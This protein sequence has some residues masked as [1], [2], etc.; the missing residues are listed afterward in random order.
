MSLLLFSSFGYVL[1]SS[2]RTVSYH[3]VRVHRSHISVRD[4]IVIPEA[5]FINSKDIAWIE[6]D[7]INYKGQ[8]FDVKSLFKQQG[9]VV[10]AGHYDKFENHLFKWL[11]KLLDSDDGNDSTSKYRKSLQ[12]LPDAIIVTYS[13]TIIYDAI[14]G[15]SKNFFQVHD[16]LSRNPVPLHQPPDPCVA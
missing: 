15:D 8:M 5:E 2:V 1:W 12:W 11:F 3:Y 6:R 7:E 16:F 13:F 4:T 10:L 14:T 9:N